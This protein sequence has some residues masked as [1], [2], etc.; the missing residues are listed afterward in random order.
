MLTPIQQDK[1]PPALLRRPA[2]RYIVAGARRVFPPVRAKYVASGWHEMQ[3][4]GSIA[5]AG[6]MAAA[7]DPTST[8]SSSSC[9]FKK[10]MRFPVSVAEAARLSF[11]LLRTTSR[12]VKTRP[13]ASLFVQTIAGLA[14]DV[15]DRRQFVVPQSDTPVRGSGRATSTSTQRR[16]RRDISKRRE[17]RRRSRRCRLDTGSGPWFFLSTPER[18]VLEILERIANP[19]SFGNVSK[20][21][22]ALATLGR[23]A[24]VPLGSCTSSR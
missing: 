18:A 8:G 16:H 17:P 3:R 11:M 13:R 15:S 1:P 21:L 4:A 10:L 23:D 19:R 5:S 20:S 9:R 6:G 7:A 24:P 14:F 12:W 22:G 2:G